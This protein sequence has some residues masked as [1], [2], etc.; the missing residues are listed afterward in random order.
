MRRSSAFL[1]ALLLVAA[2]ASPA[3]ALRPDAREEVLF[4]GTDGELHVYRIRGPQPGPTLLVLGGIHGN[5]PGGYLA[6]D[7][8]LDRI[9]PYRGQLILVPRVNFA[10]ILRGERGTTGDMNRMFG[11]TASQDPVVDALEGLIAEA[12]ALLNLH[13]GRGFYRESWVDDA[14]N[15]R[16]FGQ[17]IVLD[18]ARHTTPGGKVLELAAIAEQV[19]RSVNG[20]I[21]E[22]EYHFRVLDTRTTSPDSPFP[23]LR[24]SATY[25]ALTRRGIP[26]FGVE[27]SKDIPADA[28]RMRHQVL[29]L[30]AF[31]LALG[32]EEDPGWFPEPPQDRVDFL[33]IREGGGALRAV[34]PG[35][36]LRV[37]AGEQI[38]VES[39]EGNVE[40]GL[41]VDVEGWGGLQDLGRSITV[42]AP[43]EVLVR[44]DARLLGR[45]EIRPETRPAALPTPLVASVPARR[46]GAGSTPA[47]RVE[48]NGQG[49][50]VQDGGVLEVT[51]G[52]TVRLLDPLGFADPA[53]LV[54]DLVGFPGGGPSSSQEDRGYLVDTG[55][56][57]LQRF[58]LAGDG[59]YYRVR[60]R[61]GGH[62]RGGFHLRV[63]P[64][65]LYHVE[66]ERRRP[67]GRPARTERI[68]AD[69]TLRVARGETIRILEA[70][71]SLHRSDGVGVNLRGF[72]GAP[73]GEDRGLPVDTGRDLLARWALDPEGRLYEIVVSYHQTPV[74]RVLIEVLD[75]AG[76][77]N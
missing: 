30:R 19:A 63:L 4:P 76:L 64:P 68:P 44:K 73:D 50:L 26:A 57:L 46:P 13:D 75:A 24:A 21:P 56:A 5:E 61:E 72:P 10:S 55:S 43:V 27:T 8:L 3:R 35:E 65:R 69:G 32:L 47:F 2:L 62:D 29:V 60:A 31:L 71:T 40:R 58:S 45:I 49:R 70:K 1:L 17:S 25:Y 28:V 42:D 38:R 34:R 22:Q 66:L 54:V 37:P 7:L 39:V 53:S 20:F 52:D 59:E 51:A 33:L 15:P 67:D 74:G 77:G 41:A 14:H 9:A 16:R 23:E 36:S 12:D 48:W 6:V 11:D 18:T